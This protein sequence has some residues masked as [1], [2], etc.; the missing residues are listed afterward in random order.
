MDCNSQGATGDETKIDHQYVAVQSYH[1]KPN[2]CEIDAAPGVAYWCIP[3]YRKKK[4]R[5]TARQS[6][7]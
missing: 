4:R 7:S 6:E 3:P 2:Q 5:L 1:Y